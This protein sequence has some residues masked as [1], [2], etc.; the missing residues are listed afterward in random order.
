[1]QEAW[2]SPAICN[3]VLFA[4]DEMNTSFQEL[5][6]TCRDEWTWGSF[7]K[8]KKKGLLP[9]VILVRVSLMSDDI[10]GRKQWCTWGSHDVNR[11]LPP[12]HRMN[13]WNRTKNLWVTRLWMVRAKKTRL[14]AKMIECQ[15]GFKVKW[16]TWNHYGKV[17]FLIVDY[18]IC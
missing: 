5:C 2:I 18:L 13:T 11:G 1:M 4:L 14:R 9:W 8:K 3:A 12:C 16:E 10:T 7:L 17:F 6:L 15:S